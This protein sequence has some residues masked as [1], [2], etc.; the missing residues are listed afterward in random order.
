MALALAQKQDPSLTELIEWA[1]RVGFVAIEER[2]FVRAMGENRIPKL[3]EGKPITFID[4]ETGETRY[5]YEEHCSDAM[6]KKMAERI[7][8]DLY[9]DQVSVKVDQRT[10][11]FLPPAEMRSKFE[12]M[13]A[14]AAEKT[15]LVQASGV[16]GMLEQLDQAA[17]P[18]DAEFTEV[19]PPEKE[20][21]GLT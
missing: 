20:L 16:Q 15:R 18:I 3:F 2:V 5:V 14:N 7:R 10:T 17:R 12:E 11:V 8:P 9:G 13:L 19:K 21:A 4:I 6:L 1:M